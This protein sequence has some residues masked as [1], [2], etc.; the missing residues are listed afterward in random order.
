MPPRW[1]GVLRR[2]PHNGRDS[3]I[4]TVIGA[5]TELASLW[6]EA[7]TATDPARIAE[8]YDLLD[9]CQ[10]YSATARA[11]R[12]LAGLGFDEAGCEGFAD[13]ARPVRVFLSTGVDIVGVISSRLPGR[14]PVLGV[15]RT[16]RSAAPGLCPSPGCSCAAAA[17]D[18]G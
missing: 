1:R 2:N 12:I 3:L 8:F 10:A 17:A 9:R 4:D 16:H 13:S 15:G 18:M 6:Q 11:A 14:D 7:E 5:D